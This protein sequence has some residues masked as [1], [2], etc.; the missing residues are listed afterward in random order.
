MASGGVDGLSWYD[1]SSTFVSARP[2]PRQ[3]CAA[4]QLSYCL[5]FILARIVRRFVEPIATYLR[6]AQSNATADSD[7]RELVGQNIP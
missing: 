7:V 4:I 3:I 2:N 6:T 1:S 5:P